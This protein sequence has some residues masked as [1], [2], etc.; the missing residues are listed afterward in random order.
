MPAGQ[1]NLA[2]QVASQ[3]Q[4]VAIQN[5]QVQP[6]LMLTQSARLC[7]RRRRLILEMSNLINSEAQLDLLSAPR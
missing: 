1:V 3:Q 2:I 7:R 4:R 6:E 5:F